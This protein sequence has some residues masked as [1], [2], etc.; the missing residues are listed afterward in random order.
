MSYSVVFL[1]GSSDKRGLEGERWKPVEPLAKAAGAVFHHTGSQEEAARLVGNE[2]ERPTLLFVHMSGADLVERRSGSATVGEQEGKRFKIGALVQSVLEENGRLVLFTG[3]IFPTVP[4]QLYDLPSHIAECID[5]LEYRLH[6]TALDNSGM[7]LFFRL[8]RLQFPR[9]LTSDY[10]AESLTTSGD[11]KADQDGIR[12]PPVLLALDILIQGYLAIARPEIVFDARAEDAATRSLGVLKGPALQAAARRLAPAR[13]FSS[14]DPVDAAQAT[15]QAC[16]FAPCVP[17][18]QR[19]S[20][21]ELVASLPAAA[22]CVS[23]RVVWALLRDGSPGDQTRSQDDYTLLFEQVYWE[24]RA[25]MTGDVPANLKERLNQQRTILSHN[26]LRNDFIEQV[27]TRRSDLTTIERSR[28]IL[29]VWNPAAP[30]EDQE[31]HEQAVYLG[32]R[33]WSDV[34]RALHQFFYVSPSRYGFS[35]TQRFL[36]AR[37]RVLGS[38]ESSS[39]DD[40]AECT[41][42]DVV[43]SFARRFDSLKGASTEVQHSE[44][45]Q[46]WKALD[47]IAQTLV[48]MRPGSDGGGFDAYFIRLSIKPGA[49]C[50]AAI[51]EAT[52]REPSQG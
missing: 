44:L 4:D 41:L 11:A 30:D 32:L 34:C 38:P 45:D 47:E 21:D 40:P 51:S 52:G 43:T 17:D 7:G 26:R 1:D 46:F 14:R 39:T 29:K 27:G 25:M 33:N 13:L 36:D 37:R 49:S 2:K 6:W 42:V 8:S 10:R 12:L 19:L 3:G 16:W 20:F 5:R 18:A 24:L 22:S 50:G 23:L 31:A 35:V 48:E 28:K 9:A 15:E